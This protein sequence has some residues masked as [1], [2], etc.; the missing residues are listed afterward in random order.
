MQ[1]ISVKSNI[2]YFKVAIIVNIPVASFIYIVLF[3]MQV[4]KKKYKRIIYIYFN[5]NFK[6]LILSVLE[7][8]LL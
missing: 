6:I 3:N 7:T 8:F 1:E 2:T 4:K 5:S